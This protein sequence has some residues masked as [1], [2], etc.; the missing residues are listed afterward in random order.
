[1]LADLK[2]ALRQLAKAPAFT[3]IALV[4]LAVGIGS[5]TVVFS[6]INALLFKPLPLVSDTEDRFL[7]ITQTDPARGSDDLGWSLPDFVELQ[8]R[9]T[10]LAGSW[11]HTD[12]TVILGGTDIPERQI[13]TEITWDGFAL[14]GIQ[15]VL[16]RGFTAADTDPQSP[17]V[18]LISAALW[19]R[20]FAGAPEVL[21]TTVSLND[22][23]TTIVGVMPPAWRYP[24]FTDVW[25][26]LRANDERMA[27]RGS[28]T[29]SGR[30]R[31]KPG[32][33]LAQAQAEADT[34]M[35]ALAQEFPA[36]NAGLGVR[37][38]PIREEAVQETRQQTVLLFGAVMFVFLIACV[39]VANL[40]L[41]RAV[42]RSRFRSGCASISTAA[43]SPS[44]SR[45]RSAP[46]SCSGSSPPSASRGPMS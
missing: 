41:A 20:R 8:K 39:N 16:G 43:C 45:S 31:L 36:T 42:T 40:L 32:V 25:T 19:K 27:A 29:F 37:F 44:S 34:I 1:M 17:P 12:R 30:A 22:Q 4:T 11:I 35:A 2:F 9:A 13:G 46:P 15:P 14:M 26:P 6:A 23:P 18:A 24:D 33:T 21:G 28:F 7:F 5:A 3:A 38:R 10:T